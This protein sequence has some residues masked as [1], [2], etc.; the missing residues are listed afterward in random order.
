MS[1]V[2]F[3]LMQIWR[4]SHAGRVC[5]GDHIPDDQDCDEDLYLCFEGKFIKGMLITIY[6]IFGASLL[7]II[8]VAICVH[9]KHV[10]EDKKAIEAAGGDKS[11]AVTRVGAF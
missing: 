10:N 6:S 4:W 2:L 9:K 8:V 1:I 3:I 5:S 11:A 7:S